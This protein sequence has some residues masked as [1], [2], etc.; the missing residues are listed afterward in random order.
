LAAESDQA[1]IS[2]HCRGCG[3]CVETCPN[4]AIELIIEE[5]SYVENAIQQLSQQ[6]DVR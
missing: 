3:R 2:S 1:V 5:N 6:V 4:K